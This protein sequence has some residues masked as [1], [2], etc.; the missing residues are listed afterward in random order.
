ME[1]RP[2]VFGDNGPRCKRLDAV[3]AFL[4]PLPAKHHPD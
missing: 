3:L 2:E 4:Q 1:P